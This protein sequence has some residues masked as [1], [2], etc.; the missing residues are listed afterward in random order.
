MTDRA[1]STS[2]RE[3]LLAAADHL[4]YSQGYHATGINQIIDEAEVAKASFYNHFQ[5]KDELALAY[6]KDRHE[7]RLASLREQVEVHA[8]IE[9]R[10]SDVF[11]H[12]ETFALEDQFRGCGQ[13]NMAAEF[14]KDDHPVRVQIRTHKQSVRNFLRNL[15]SG[16]SSGEAKENAE[17]LARSVYLLYEA[18]LVESQTLSDLW[19]IQKA[20]EAALRLVAASERSA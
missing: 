16:S 18:A 15:L 17:Q 9:K 7:R 19:P 13:L 5:S 10:I 2:A 3:R 12:L 4:F 6:L 20:K 11:E 8:S 14:P 1:K